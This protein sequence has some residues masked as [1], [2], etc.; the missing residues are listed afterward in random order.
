MQ[1]GFFVPVPQPLPLCNVYIWAFMFTFVFQRCY[2]W[3]VRVWWWFPAWKWR[4]E[5][6]PP[7]SHSSR[8]VISFLTSSTWRRS[9]LSPQT[10]GNISNS[11]YNFSTHF[12]IYKTKSKVWMNMCLNYFRNT[13]VNMFEVSWRVLLS[14]CLFKILLLT[15]YFCS[16]HLPFMSVFC[17]PVP[18]KQKYFCLSLLCYFFFLSFFY[19]S[20]TFVFSAQVF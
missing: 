7:P 5:T 15:Q 11:E 12:L 19:C 3:K 6:F 16:C 13:D 14:F 2:K 10:S 18:Q 1:T 9:F 20:Q 8:D 4:E 17:P